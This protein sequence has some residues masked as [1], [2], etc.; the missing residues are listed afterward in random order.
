MI[1]KFLQ[2]KFPIN[3]LDKKINKFGETIGKIENLRNHV[4]ESQLH[5][6][7]FFL[8]LFDKELRFLIV[9]FLEDQSQ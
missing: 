6:K 7:K 1:T 8:S 9:L 3:V 5:R 4:L 2:D